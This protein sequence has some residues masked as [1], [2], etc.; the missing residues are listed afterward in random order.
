[1][2]GLITADS[3]VVRAYRDVA[4][5]WGGDRDSPKDYQ[6]FSAARS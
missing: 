6:H 2:K 4:W 1:M 5:E 3:V